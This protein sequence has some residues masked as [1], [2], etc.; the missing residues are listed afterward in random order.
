GLDDSKQLN[1]TTRHAFFE[2]IKQQA[3]SY[4]ISIVDNQLIDKLNIFAATKNA[5]FDAVNKLNPKPD[6]LLIDAISLDNLPCSSE[7]IVKGDSASISIAAASILAKVTRD[8]IMKEIDTLFP[9]YGF[10]S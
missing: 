1:E 5:M 3:V 8:L 7:S 6:H 2:Q 9:Q 10:A 4:G